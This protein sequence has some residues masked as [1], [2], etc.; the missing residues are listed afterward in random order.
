MTSIVPTSSPTPST[1][2]HYRAVA[3]PVHTILVLAVLGTWAFGSRI[4]GRPLIMGLGSHPV[5]LYL[6][7]AFAEWFMF[8]L[9]MAGAR[10]YG[11]SINALL[12]SRWRSGRQLLRDVGIAAAFWLI[13]VALLWL[14]SLIWH[15]AP[16]GNVLSVLPHGIVE[17]IA[18]IGLAVTAG[19]C[20][21]TIFRGYLQRQFIAVTHSV[22]AGI[23]LSAAIFGVAHAYEGPRM[24][25]PIG[26]YG[27][28]FGILSHW[29]RSIRP[30]MIAHAWHDALIGI[31]V[32]FIKH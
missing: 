20:E 14:L 13:S 24:I 29:R 17:V 32:S 1:S 6:L 25:L 15:F 30:G 31:V 26:L 4:L 27:V 9:V 19:I 10:F 12:G 3:G 22:P 21:E 23:L 11:T 8:A 2:G 28:M 18:W 7:T 16:N 5:R